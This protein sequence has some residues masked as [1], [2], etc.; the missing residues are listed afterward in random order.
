[1]AGATISL[2]WLPKTTAA[3][4]QAFPDPSGVPAGKADV[5]T[6]SFPVFAAAQVPV[7]ATFLP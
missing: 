4:A 2:N 7:F 5:R 1:M 3:V 6:Y